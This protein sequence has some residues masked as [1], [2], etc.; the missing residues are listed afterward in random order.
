MLVVLSL[1]G[2]GLLAML[3]DEPDYNCDPRAAWYPDADG[4]GV[5]EPTAVYI[6]CDAPAGYVST[7]AWPDDTDSDALDTDPSDTD[8]GAGG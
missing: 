5:G 6:G 1:L 2:C 3:P 8:A 7:V 4:D